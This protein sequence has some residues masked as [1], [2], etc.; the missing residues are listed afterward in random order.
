MVGVTKAPSPPYRRGSNRP[1]V[2]SQQ[3]TG[4]P[5]R[6]NPQRQGVG[7][8]CGRSTGIALYLMHT[9]FANRRT[10]THQNPETQT[11]QHPPPKKPTRTKT[12]NEKNTEPATER[13]K[14]KKTGAGR[15]LDEEE[16]EE[17]RVEVGVRVQDEETLGETQ[18]PQ[19]FVVPQHLRERERERQREK[20]NVVD[21]HPNNQKEKRTTNNTPKKGQVLKGTKPNNISTPETKNTTQTNQT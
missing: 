12:R 10:R 3:E 18:T 8:L 15:S 21:E 20:E 17:V 7:R 9:C 19:G 5:G 6:L 16:R 4:N 14:K 1:R 13:R 11:D 2:D